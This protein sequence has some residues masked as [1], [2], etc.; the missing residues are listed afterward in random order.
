VKRRE[1]IA[2]LGVAAWPLMAWAQQPERMRRV[3]L[4]ANRTASDPESSIYA[5]AFVQEM[6]RLGWTEGRNIQFDFRLAGN[7]VSHYGAYATELLALA[8]DVIVTLGGSVTGIVQQATRAV[9][10]VFASVIDPVGGGFVASLSRP[11]G[12]ATGFASRDYSF[13]GK[14]LELLKEIAPRVTRATVLRN[15][16]IAGGG[17]LGALQAVAPSLGVDLT[18]FN[19]RDASEIERAITTF[20]RDPN[21]GLIVTGSTGAVTYRDLI[22]MLAAQHRLP[23]VYPNRLFTAAGGL[24]S[25][26]QDVN[27]VPTRNAASYVDRILRGAKPADLP[28]QTLTKFE[29]VINLKTAKTLGLVIPERL[30]ATADEVIQ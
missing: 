21:N 4:L 25:Y 5:A 1:F 16:S 24:I 23:A 2:G 13:S 26:G 10:I 22:V 3:A 29:L 27:D 18:P 11:G 14:W 9:P 30:L 7:D 6:L 15:A 28:V 19:A 20:G 17:Q 12:N 8:P